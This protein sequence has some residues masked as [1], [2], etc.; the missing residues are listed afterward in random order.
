MLKQSI[1]YLVASILVVLFAKYIYLIILYIDMTYVYI[2]VKLAPIFSRSALGILIRKIVT[3]TVIPIAL[4]AIP[5][6]IYWVI[7]RRFMPYFIQLVWLFWV[8]IVLSKI[9]IR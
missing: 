4:S 7:K 2:N 1:I 9:L 8:I 5:A 6:L 3:L